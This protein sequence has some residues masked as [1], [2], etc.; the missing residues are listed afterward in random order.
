MGT[1]TLHPCDNLSIKLST[2][3]ILQRSFEVSCGV[4]NDLRGTKEAA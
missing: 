2:E 1:F 4:K 3:I